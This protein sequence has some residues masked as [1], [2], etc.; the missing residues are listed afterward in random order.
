MSDKEIVEIEMT[1]KIINPKL[2]ILDTTWSCDECIIVDGVTG[3]Y[4][5]L[6]L[7]EDKSK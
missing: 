6:K 1:S 4:K 3:V 7:K 5:I 2:K